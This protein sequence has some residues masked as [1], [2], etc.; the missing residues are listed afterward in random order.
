MK[1]VELRNRCCPTLWHLR[2]E[3]RNAAVRLRRKPHIIQARIRHAGC[4]RNWVVH[5]LLQH[6]AEHRGAIAARV[7]RPPGEG[8]GGCRLTGAA[9]AGPA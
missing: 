2:S 9:T 3:I 8:T 1:R 6:E 7:G 4:A 5:H